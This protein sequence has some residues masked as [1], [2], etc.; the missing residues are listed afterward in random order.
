VVADS[1]E[2]VKHGVDPKNTVGE[3]LYTPKLKPFSV[4]LKPPV[5]GPFAFTATVGT[6]ASYVK[7]LTNV[8]TTPATDSETEIAEESPD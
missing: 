3:L 4:T 5:L 8:P 2:A 7:I 1:H 6:G